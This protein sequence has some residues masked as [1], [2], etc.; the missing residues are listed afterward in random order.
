MSDL[1]LATRELFVRSLKQQVWYK[2]PFYE[3]LDRRKKITFRGGKYIERLIV[4]DDLE[5]LAQA[6]TTNEMLTDEA[7]DQLEK[8]RF[9]WKYLQLPLRYTVDWMVQNAGAG[10]E[11]QLLDL[12]EFL[13]RQG[14]MGLKK[15]MM[16]NL[17][18]GGTATGRG[19]GQKEFQSLIS[20]LD[21]DITYG[22]LS[23]SWSAGTNDYW[24]GAD[25]AAL[26][27]NVSSSA[28]GTSYNLTISNLRKWIN[29]SDVGQY[30]EQKSD[31][32]IV[33]C[34]KLFNKLRAEM[35]SK[36]IYKPTGDTQRQ[37]FNK[38]DLDGHTIV[39]VPHLQTTS[40]MQTWLFI[41]NM[42]DWELRI[43]TERNFELTPFDWQ[44]K[45]TNGHDYW[46][47]RIM[48]T[49][50]LCCWKPRGNLWLSA[51]S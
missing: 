49:G 15:K 23:R 4:K 29:E 28:Q 47:A 12:P 25:P 22:T 43:S 10:N 13:V 42:E 24:Q 7:K 8:P 51:V 2:M 5:S 40:T 11:E 27:I 26:N 6:Y 36:M 18:N 33:M 3:E 50:N 34:P 48:A 19:D 46:L 32:Y 21:H 14:Q 30:M 44:G 17:F 39:D 41:I 38:M 37:G 1:T 35:E 9:T 31:L 16:G 45:Y 20:A